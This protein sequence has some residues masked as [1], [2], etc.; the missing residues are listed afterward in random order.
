[1]SLQIRHTTFEKEEEFKQLVELQNIVY[2]HRGLHFS[3]DGF[4]YWYKKNPVGNVVAH[5]AFDGNKMVA[6]YACIPTQMSID[7]VCVNG[8]LSMAV[9]T[10]PDYRGHG[11]FT[12]L[13]TKTYELARDL[14]YEFVVGVANANS[15]PIFMKHFPFNYIGQLDVK[16]GWG[17]I[18]IPNKMFSHYW[19]DKTIQWRTN[20]PKYSKYKN[21]I[22]GLYGKLPFIKTFMGEIPE[23]LSNGLKLKLTKHFIRPFNLYV[24]MGADFSYGHYFDVPKFVKH[25]PFHLRFMDITPDKHLPTVNKENIVF[26]LI[27]FD[28]A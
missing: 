12:T 22:Y 28:V 18:K 16:W 19:T 23:Q 21:N 14:G 20:K 10:H 24:G 13:A 15:F 25:S 26:Q 27:D 6:H 1:M 5:S 17:E 8:L 9:V 4:R 11:L 7:G 3:T 2:Q